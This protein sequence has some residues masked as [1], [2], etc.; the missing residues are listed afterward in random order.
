MVTEAGTRFIGDPASGIPDSAA[1]INV[2]EP[3]RIKPF[4]ESADRLECLPPDHQTGGGGLVYFPERLMAVP[5]H[6]VPACPRIPGPEHI[7]Q[8]R[9]GCH[10]AEGWEGANV[11]T[12]LG[13]AGTV[14]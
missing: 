9:V 3:G 14:D 11:E 12:D 2:L 8:K 6:Q 4:V 13:S 7:E 1:K 10:A 5:Q